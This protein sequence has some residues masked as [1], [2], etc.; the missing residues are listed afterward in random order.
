MV[1]PVEEHEVT[2]VNSMLPQP[3]LV[4]RMRRETPDTFTIEIEPANGDKASRFAPGQFNMLYVFGCGE[5]AISI[6]ADPRGKSLMHTTRVVGTV[7]KAMAKLRRG[8]M[9]GV[10][11]P[12]GSGWPLE[13]VAGRD[14]VVV[15]GGIGLAPLRGALCQLLRRRKR[16][17]RVVLLCGVRTPADILYRRELERWRNRGLQIY[18]TVDRAT[19]S[20]LGHV[21]VVTTL[22]PR[23]PFDPV[24]AVALVCGPEVMMRYTALELQKRGVS[25][26]S[27]FLSM[28]RN[29]KCAIGFCGHCQFGPEFIC[30]D[31][32][33]FRYDHIKK[34]LGIWEL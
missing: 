29:M 17:G 9:L 27:I 1:F 16:P 11:G 23:A 12:F 20:W 26:T 4:R 28:E 31:G 13:Q 10:R 22:I 32:P 2:S 15:T 19:G 30:K 7:T 14:V 34:W 33:V 6:C 8:D 5:I 25:E 21:G 24:N 3:F 18:V